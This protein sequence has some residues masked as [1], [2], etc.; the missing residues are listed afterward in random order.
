MLGICCNVCFDIDYLH[1][2]THNC[3]DKGIERNLLGNGADVGGRGQFGDSACGRARTA[4]PRGGFSVW[5]F[6]LGCFVFT[7]TSF[8]LPPSE[9]TALGVPVWWFFL[10]RFT[11][12][13]TSF[14]S[15]PSDVRAFGVVEVK[16]AAGH[17]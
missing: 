4:V 15:S 10:G 1:D 9:V 7:L 8:V 16:P 2:K 5:F 13:L 3:N 17:R 11:F 12:A 6:F 14:V